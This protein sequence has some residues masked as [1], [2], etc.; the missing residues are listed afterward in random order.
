M[1]SIGKSAAEVEQRI[2]VGPAGSVD[3]SGA[4]SVEA[5]D[6]KVGVCRVTAKTDESTVRLTSQRSRRAR[7]IRR[8]EDPTPV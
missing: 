8:G 6:V 5:K 1:D 2:G 7:L 3:A 4:D